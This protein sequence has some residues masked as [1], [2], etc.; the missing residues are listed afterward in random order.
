MRI[1]V[2]ICTWNRA[3]SLAQTLQSVQVARSNARSPVEVIVVNNNCSDTTDEVLARLARRI[4]VVRVFEPRPGLSH[5]RNAAIEAATGDYI[6]WTDDDVDVDAGW[7]AAYEAAF[8]A[9]PMASFYGGPIVPLF[10]GDPPAWLTEAWS[11]VS[12]AYAGRN[13]GSAER[14][15]SCERLPYGANFAVRCREQK[16]RPFDPRFG[17]RPDDY[18]LIGEESH[19]MRGLLDDGHSGWWVPGACV[20]HRIS[21]D[22]QTLDYLQ[23]Y[24]EGMGRTILLESRLRG[25]A[26]RQ[27]L[28]TDALQRWLRAE[29]RCLWLRLTSPPE[30]WVP[31]MAERSI[32]RGWIEAWLRRDGARPRDFRVD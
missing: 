17:R 13:L 7:L 1:S 30:R 8:A 24:F 9:H 18:W 20:Q 28:P 31:K 25:E 2:A 23:H 10:E 4:P 26:S 21:A 29:V 12:D 3:S 11:S 22:R 32:A 14:E 15:L 27:G 6:V 16:L 19:L 5:A